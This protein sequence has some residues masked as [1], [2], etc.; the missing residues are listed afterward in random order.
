MKASSSASHLTILTGSSRGLGLALANQLLASGDTLLCIS[1]S[2]KPDLTAVAQLRG[3]NLLQW[4]LDLAD[5]AVA[6]DQLRQWLGT[7]ATTRWSTATLINNAAMLP[8]AVP[9]CDAE[10]HELAQALRVGLEAPLLLTAAFLNATMGWMYN[11]GQPTLRRVLNISSGNGQRALAS[12]A[13]YS[14]A[15]AGMDHYTRC[16]ALEEARRS[17]GARVCSLDPGGIDTDMQTQLRNSDPSSFPNHAMFV[18]YKADNLLL[19]PQAA[20]ARV[21]VYLVQPDFGT[22]VVAQVNG[23]NSQ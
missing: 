3:A 2:V 19:T 7:Q 5:G 14:A 18:A 8:R 21:L 15:K 22:N 10:P 1:R 6:A 13:A 11:D 20:A 16:L 4:P 23:L 17:N 9:L 12:M